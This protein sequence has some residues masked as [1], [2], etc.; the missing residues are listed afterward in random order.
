[1]YVCV[2]TH[3]YSC[4]RIRSYNYTYMYVCKTR[5]ATINTTFTTTTALL[6][7]ILV[8]YDSLNSSSSICCYAAMY[9]LQHH[10][11]YS[12]LKCYSIL[13]CTWKMMLEV[14]LWS[15]A[16]KLLHSAFCAWNNNRITHTFIFSQFT[17]NNI[18][19]Y[20]IWNF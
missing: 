14:G 4:V 3:T 6:S 5:L 10:K 17:F 7:C 12:F 1:M 8:V 16:Y 2:C 11:I 13:K 15:I 9:I 19:F 20:F 18:I